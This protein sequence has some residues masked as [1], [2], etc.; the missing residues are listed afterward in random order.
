M[1]KI[2]FSE[3]SIFQNALRRFCE[4]AVVS[5]DLTDEVTSVLSD[6][7]KRGDRAVFEYTDKF[8]QA[9]LTAKTMRVTPEDLKA[10]VKCLSAADRKAI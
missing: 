10:S 8:D 4:Q 2:E 1:Q 5:G 3:S 6:V 9:K 7:E